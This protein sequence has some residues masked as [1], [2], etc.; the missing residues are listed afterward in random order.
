MRQNVHFQVIKHENWDGTGR[1][2]PDLALIKLA[3]DVKIETDIENLPVLPIC[4]P[5]KPI[6]LSNEVCKNK[7]NKEI[8]KNIIH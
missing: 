6:P 7:V 4:L 3:R 5:N 8:F 2:L 1:T